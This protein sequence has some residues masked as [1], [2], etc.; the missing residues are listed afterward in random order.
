MQNSSGSTD[1]HQP[2]MDDERKASLREAEALQSELRRAKR[3]LGE[4]A[5]LKRPKNRGKESTWPVAVECSVETPKGAKQYDVEELVVRVEFDGGDDGG[6]IESKAFCSNPALPERLNDTMSKAVGVRWDEL[7]S[8]KQEWPVTELYQWVEGNF[9]S[10]ISKEPLCME[11]YTSVDE[12]GATLRRVAFVEPPSS[13]EDDQG[14][15]AGILQELDHLGKRSNWELAWEKLEGGVRFCI[16]AVPVDPEWKAAK[17]DQ[18]IPMSGYLPADF[19]ESKCKLICTSSDENFGKLIGKAVEKYAASATGRPLNPRQLVHFVENHA[20]G[21]LA[22]LDGVDPAKGNAT[23][24]AQA[25][26][27]DGTLSLASEESNESNPCA[28]DSAR[29]DP[30]G[31]LASQQHSGQETVLSLEELEMRGICMMQYASLIVLVSCSHCRTTHEVRFDPGNALRRWVC[32]HCDR[33]SEV[34]AERTMVHE[35]SDTVSVLRC[36]GCV[37]QEVPFL[38]L[39]TCCSSCDDTTTVRVSSGRPVRFACHGCHAPCRMSYARCLSSTPASRPTRPC[40]TPLRPGQPLPLRG[41]CRHYRRSFRWM[42]FPCCGR[43]FPCD[44]CHELGGTNEGCQPHI[45]ATRMACGF[46]AQEQA[47]G[48]QCVHCGA[49]LTAQGKEKTH[50]RYWEGGKGCRNRAQLSRRD[51]KKYAGLNKTKKKS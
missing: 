32:H 10:L 38:S 51:P 29:L 36:E 11:E 21:I 30:S 23:S 35:S 22:L 50:T 6:T 24:E 33:P 18:K 28:Q 7:R 20:G 40:A 4:R 45:R 3:E 39:S 46:C 37:P 47:F 1:V 48:A 34:F 43:W 16:K 5:R 25:M 8:T 17:G 44:V 26:S 41:T 42:R 49:K 19:P 14:L 2:T 9:V 31:A 13:S 27:T 15:P 12:L